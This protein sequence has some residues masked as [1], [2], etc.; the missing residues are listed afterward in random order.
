MQRQFHIQPSVYLA[1][2]LLAAHGMA[3]LAIYTLPLPV[4]TKIGL[5][6][7]L[8]LSLIFYW[9]RDARL[10]APSAVIALTLQDEQ[11]VLTARNGQQW[12]T[13][14]SSHSMVFPGLIVLDSL[15]Q[16]ANRAHSI[17]LLPDSLDSASL[18]RLRVMLKWGCRS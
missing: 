12:S 9:R 2:L 15:P 6:P 14:L 1:A 7:L 3:L 8:L 11:V 18:R 4:W 10:T 5:T 17:V 16:S 13:Q